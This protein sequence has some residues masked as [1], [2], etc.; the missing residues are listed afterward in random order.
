ME[1]VA[2]QRKPDERRWGLIPSILLHI[3]F[4]AALFLLPVVAMPIPQ[5][6]DSI[7]VEMVP[8]PK[9]QAQ[10]AAKPQEQR[11][12]RLPTPTPRPDQKDPSKEKAASTDKTEGEQTADKLSDKSKTKTEKG[13]DPNAQ[14]QNAK[15]Q[16]PAQADKPA[17]VKADQPSPATQQ[18]D[19]QPQPSDTPSPTPADDQAK[20]QD[21][22][23]DHAQAQQQDQTPPNSDPATEAQKPDQTPQTKDANTQPQQQT[24]D[25]PALDASA[26]QVAAEANVQPQADV[27]PPASDAASQQQQAQE[28]AKADAEAKAAKPDAAT[29]ATDP[30]SSDPAS[31][32]TPQELATDQASDTQV[33]EP[34]KPS[35][36]QAGTQAD[37]KDGAASDPIAG[38]AKTAEGQVDQNSQQQAAADPKVASDVAVPTTGGALP[39]QQSQDQSISGGASDPT[40]GTTFVPEPQP[41]PQQQPSSADGTQQAS[42]SDPSQT[43]Q[44]SGDKTGGQQGKFIQAK[45]FYSGTEMARMSKDEL[46]AWKKLPR[47][48][49][50]R[51]LCNSEEKLQFGH[52]LH[53]VGFINSA[54]SPAMISPTGLYGDGVAIQTSKGWQQVQFKCQ[55]DEDALKVAAFSYAVK[56]RVPASRL[57]KLGVPSN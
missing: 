5:P 33:M 36:D 52:E 45:R 25:Q 16:E 19:A 46:D 23:G 10:N 53:A 34:D 41:R 20:P 54:L 13:P 31:M 44:K 32:P 57:E 12:G 48:E 21:Q 9:E 28:V 4:F 35:T 14:E 8:Q 6:E 29:S 2:E 39:Q 55:V 38:Q 7:N 1:R 26:S 3:L 24:A 30:N 50:V 18:A 15:S 49:R 22:T 40:A 17:D 42:I 56:G 27:T 47:L 37:Q 11:S 43:Q 51:Q